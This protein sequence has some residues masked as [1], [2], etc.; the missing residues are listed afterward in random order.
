MTFSDLTI[1]KLPLVDC[2]EM[3]TEAHALEAEWLLHLAVT[4]VMLTV[5]T[6]VWNGSFVCT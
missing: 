1:V 2:D 6:V 3:P 5:K 4:T